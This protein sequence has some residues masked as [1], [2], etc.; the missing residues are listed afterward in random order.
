MNSKSIYIILFAISLFFSCK[1]HKKN[2]ED[3][4]ISELEAMSDNSM[5][6]LDWAGTYEGVLPCA[7]CEGIKTTMTINKDNTF[8]AREIYIGKKDSVIESK[9]RFKWDEKGQII[10]FSDK[11]RHSYF[12]GEN[13]LI[14]L[15]SNGDKITG[16]LADKYVLTKSE[17]KLVGK[18]WHLV[19][20]KGEEIQLKEAKAERPNIEFMEDDT[21]FGYTGCNEFR[22][23]YSLKEGYEISFSNIIST[24]MFCPEMETENEFLNVMGKASYYIFEDHALVIHDENHQALATFK[25][26]N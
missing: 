16:D 13:T 12:V 5:T 24:K 4:S 21:M 6:S 19:S 3:L 14:H 25:P 20:F 2:T 23:G 15:D 11:K 9:G 17:E 8:A 22:G 18:K 26:A 1:D 7:D 10:A